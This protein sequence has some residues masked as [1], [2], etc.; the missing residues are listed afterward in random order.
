APGFAWLLS[1]LGLLPRGL[2]LGVWCLAKFAAV[3]AV[4]LALAKRLPGKSLESNL[5]L[6]AF[7][8]LVVARPF[9]IDVGYGQVNVFIL[10]SAVWALLV[11][12]DPSSQKLGAGRS[13]G[14]LSGGSSQAPFLSWA[15]LS[16]AA[17]AKIFPLPLLIVP[18]LV[19]KGI[20]REKLA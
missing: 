5:A 10:A 12:M 6:A 14:L 19:G 4:L 11:H 9:L 20:P 7:G 18:F 16:C 3:G 1:P 13:V 17:V 8:V 15:L 2:A